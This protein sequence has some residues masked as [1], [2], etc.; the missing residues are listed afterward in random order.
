MEILG[1]I[2]QRPVSALVTVARVI[3]RYLLRT[4]LRLGNSL[5]RDVKVL[6]KAV[7]ICLG[8]GYRSLAKALIQWFAREPRAS[9]LVE[10][11][12]IRTAQAR[13]IGLHR[14]PESRLQ[15]R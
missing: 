1:R 2:L 3:K 8:P 5:S 12:G 9:Q 13:H 6:Q 10:P 15:I 4:L 7:H 14:E 11:L